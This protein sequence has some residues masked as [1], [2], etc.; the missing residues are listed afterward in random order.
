MANMVQVQIVGK[1]QGVKYHYCEFWGMVFSNT[2]LMLRQILN[3]SE[4]AV[5][6]GRCEDDTLLRQLR[7]NCA[8]SFKDRIKSL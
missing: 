2:V 4:S 1:L 7:S 6:S 3:D 5:V 8:N